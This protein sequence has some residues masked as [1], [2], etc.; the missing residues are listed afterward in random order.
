M[1]RPSAGPTLGNTVLNKM[2]SSMPSR[3]PVSQ[4]VSTTRRMSDRT[5]R[6]FDNVGP[7]DIRALPRAALSVLRDLYLDIERRCQWPWQLMVNLVALK[8][9]PTSGDRGIAL[10]PWLIRLWTQLRDAPTR[11]WTSEHAGFW[12]QAVAGSSALKVALSRLVDDEIVQTLGTH[13]GCLYTD[14]KEFYD[15]LCPVKTL[16]AALDLGFP[17]TIA[18]LSF[19]SYQGVRF[20]QGPDGCSLHLQSTRGIITGDKNSNNFARAADQRMVGRPCAKNVWTCRSHST[21]FGEAGLFVL[22]GLREAGFTISPKTTLVTTDRGLSAQLV[23]E[24]RTAGFPVHSALTAADLGVDR[25]FATRRRI[26]KHTKRWKNAWLRA[27]KISRLARNLTSAR[28]TRMLAV[29]GNASLSH[30]FQQAVG[31]GSFAIGSSA[32]SHGEGAHATE[33]EPVPHYHAGHCYGP[34]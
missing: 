22:N 2:T 26:P 10:I 7:A 15:Y 17:A 24:F 8:P 4:I 9:K 32:Y 16:K 5:G 25:G 21:P 27:K 29:T 33:R 19:S 6:G 23:Q 12:D 20:L 3:I 34:E 13:T 31:H 18:V 14:I 1:P 11:V 28:T 30:V